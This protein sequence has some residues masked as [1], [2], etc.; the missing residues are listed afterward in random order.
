VCVGDAHAR[1]QEGQ[2]EIPPHEIFKNMKAT[3]IFSLLGKTTSWNHF[4][5]PKTSLGGKVT[6][7]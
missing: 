1:S 3:K 2:P 4:A 6:K 7:S 5:P